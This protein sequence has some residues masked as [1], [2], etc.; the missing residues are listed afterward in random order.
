MTDHACVLLAPGFEEIEAITVI[1]VLR[2]AEIPTT[3]V[4][5]STIDV[6]GSHGITIRADA[7]LADVAGTTW[8]AVI[9][10]GGMPG[11]ANLRD[12]PAVQALVRT[13]HA[14]GRLVGAI[15]AAPIALASA[16][17]LDDRAATSYPG[18]DDQL[19]TAI[20]KQEP[21]VIDGNVVTSRA[22]GTAL[23]FALQLVE[24]LR[25]AAT[26]ATLRTQ[27]LVPAN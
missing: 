3:V 7:L 21:V 4:G 8:R 23:W 25:D 2:R 22:P 17:V 26:A 12:D 1:D 10:P 14:S 20:Y 6:T 27:M 16:G 13:H 11:A 19:G 15:C 18:F 9:L 24:Q 5:V